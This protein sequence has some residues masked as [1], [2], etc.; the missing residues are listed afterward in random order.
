MHHYSDGEI[1]AYALREALMEKAARDKSRR[2]AKGKAANGSKLAKS[3]PKAIK[4]LPP[5]SQPVRPLTITNL[6]PD[7]EA[8]MA[9]MS[10]I[11]RENA[12]S[13]PK[14]ART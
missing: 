12:L 10:V 3:G 6:A 4:T 8:A 5:V 14:P 7:L 11:H 1:L 9:A 2:V 13:R